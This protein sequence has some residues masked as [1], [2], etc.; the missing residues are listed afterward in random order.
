M[1]KKT[2]KFYEE[3]DKIANSREL[4][5]P[6]AVP[7][8]ELHRFFLEITITCPHTKSFQNALPAKQKLHLSERF[9]AIVVALNYFTIIERI[10][11]FE[12]HQTGHLHAHGLL[13][14]ESDRP[15]LPIHIVVTAVKAYL[16]TMPKQRGYNMYVD[17]CYFPDWER[18]KSPM[19]LCQ[20]R[21][22]SKT[23]RYNEWKTYINKFSQYNI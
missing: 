7:K 15:V 17:K 8:Q 1:S 14:L 20:Y 11:N 3:M 19:I 13:V 18:Y 22:I 9:K 12:F 2:V 6:P 4:S 23:D 16:M 5:C 21:D 10:L